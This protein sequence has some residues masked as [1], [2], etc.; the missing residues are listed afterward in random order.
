MTEK[1]KY[2]THY[3]AH[4]VCSFVNEA[5]VYE[6][7]SESFCQW[8][9]SRIITRTFKALNVLSSEICI[10]ARFVVHDHRLK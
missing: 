10:R 7:H 2:V 1:L 4:S 9:S 6:E 8:I 5:S 3:L